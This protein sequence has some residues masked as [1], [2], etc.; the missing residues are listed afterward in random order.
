[1]RGVSIERR[2]GRRCVE[3][4]VEIR[5]KKRICGV[6]GNRIVNRYGVKGVI[7]ILVGQIQHAVSGVITSWNCV[8]NRFVADVDVVV[9]V[10]YDTVTVVNTI[11]VEVNVIYVRHVDISHGC[12]VVDVVEVVDVVHV[13]VVEVVDVVHVDVVEV[14][15]IVDIGNVTHVDVIHVDVVVAGVI[16]AVEVHIYATLVGNCNVLLQIV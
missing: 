1:L 5:V 3:G 11:V 8:R 4:N 9:G 2:V 15:H 16:H 7:E 10:R 13:D 14:I 12:H 6:S